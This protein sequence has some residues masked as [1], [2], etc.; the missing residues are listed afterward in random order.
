MREYF[1]RRLCSNANFTELFE[2]LFGGENIFNSHAEFQAFIITFANFCAHH[3]KA[4]L[5][6]CS[7]RECVCVCAPRKCSVSI[8]IHYSFNCHRVSKPS[9]LAF[10]FFFERCDDKL[11]FTGACSTARMTWHQVEY[12]Q[13][14]GTLNDSHRKIVGNV[15]THFQAG[16]NIA[17]V[18]S[19]RVR[20]PTWPVGLLEVY[21]RLNSN[22]AVFIHQVL[23]W[24]C[25]NMFFL[26][27]L[28]V[29]LAWQQLIA[30][31]M[32]TN[33]RDFRAENTAPAALSEQHAPVK[34][35][36]IFVLYF[37][38]TPLI[39]WTKFV[40]IRYSFQYLLIYHQLI[41]LADD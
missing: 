11:L 29:F 20:S 28:S 8:V 21:N 5:P 32:P 9:L 18:S 3:D 4:E 23:L 36:Q 17:K 2:Y 26:A 27:T 34:R 22:F 39:K 33:I 19:A 31:K 14:L 12:F 6:I 15:S 40:E 7:S 25:G 1:L 16:L 24:M 38:Q 35:G 10:R 41:P 30:A 37:K 13:V